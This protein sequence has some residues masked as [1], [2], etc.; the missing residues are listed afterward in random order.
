MPNAASVSVGSPEINPRPDSISAVIGLTLATA[1]SQPSS[2]LSG[3][4]T[5]AKK[6]RMKTGICITGNA[7]CVR[8]RIATPAAQNVPAMLS[9][10]PSR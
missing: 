10:S 7:C 9:S 3:T 6:S 8:S 5:G 1:C 4:Y 2:R